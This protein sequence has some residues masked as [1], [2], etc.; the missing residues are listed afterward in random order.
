MYHAVEPDELTIHA[1]FVA[2]PARGDSK[3]APVERGP[4][5]NEEAELVCRPPECAQSICHE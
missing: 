3:L 4:R 2:I 1:A 5:G